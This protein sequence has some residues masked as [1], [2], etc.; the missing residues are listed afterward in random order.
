MGLVELS[1]SIL[2]QLEQ[3]GIKYPDP[4][5]TDMQTLKTSLESIECMFKFKEK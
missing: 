3:K 2:K 4:L 1:Y 5:Y